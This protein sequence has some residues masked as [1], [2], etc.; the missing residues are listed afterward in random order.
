MNSIEL[1][2]E[3]V[4]AKFEQVMACQ[5]ATRAVRIR[6]CSS[7][8]SRI[9]DFE[10]RVNPPSVATDLRGTHDISL[11]DPTPLINAESAPL[12]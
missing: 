4:S 2:V 11:D 12:M 7:R 10:Q 9:M 5:S 8:L 3:I 1:F 6:S